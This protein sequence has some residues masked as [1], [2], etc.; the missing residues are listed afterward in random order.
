MVGS[1]CDS[2]PR[3]RGAALIVHGHDSTSA[4][5]LAKASQS[6][7]VYGFGG[8]DDQQIAH[9]ASCGSSRETGTP[10]ENALRCQRIDHFRRRLR[11]LQREFVEEGRRDER[12]ALNLR[13]LV[14]EAEARA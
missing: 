6:S 9:A 5:A 14:G 4:S 3:L 8:G 2:L 10:R 12:N 13:E 11:Q 7:S 1:S